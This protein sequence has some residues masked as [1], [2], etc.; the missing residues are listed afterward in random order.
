MSELSLA[1]SSSL[2]EVVRAAVV[3]S[4]TVAVASAVNQADAKRAAATAADAT[5]ATAARSQQLDA[6][7][8]ACVAD[9]VAPLSAELSSLHTA[10]SAL[11]V[12][13]SDDVTT[14]ADDVKTEV[15][16]SSNNLHLEM[17]RQLH[18]QQTE[19][20]ALLQ[21]QTS[22]NAGMLKEMTDLRRQ[23]ESLRH[24]Y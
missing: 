3:D 9:A 17:I 7:V 15:K 24:I 18:T 14:A 23:Y 1:L 21:Q 5:A 4:V 6:L 13:V 20:R 11:A 2:K 16:A 12:S 8:R 10:V 19:M 22:A